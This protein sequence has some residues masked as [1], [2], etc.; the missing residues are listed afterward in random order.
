MTSLP[1]NL[2]R[3][4]DAVL[5]QRLDALGL[6]G[7]TTLRTHNNRTVML[8]LSD[9]VLRIHQG[10]AMAPDRVLQAIVRFL[11]PRIPRRLRRALQHTFLSFPVDLHAPAPA[12][13]SKRSERPRPGDVRILHDLARSHER[14]NLLHFDGQLSEI[15]FRLSGR[16]KTRLG[17]LSVNPKTGQALEIGISRA[18]LRHD[19]WDEVEQT[20]LHEMVHQW[21][22]ETGLGLDHG[23][24]FR[25]KAIQVGIEPRARRMP[26]EG[27]EKGCARI[28]T[29]G[30]E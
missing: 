30:S 4:P 12:R 5:R 9:G 29:P 1:L 7:V 14:L 24:A 22:V 25:R 21:Q 20:V 8:T 11:R 16:M 17:E 10:Y 23:A 18:H 19:S 15:P 13:R 27:P 28:A 6:D 2:V 3:A 26:G